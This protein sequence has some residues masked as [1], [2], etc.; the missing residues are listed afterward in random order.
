MVILMKLRRLFILLSNISLASAAVCFFLIINGGS[1]IFLLITILS[2][3]INI[4][5]IP[6]STLKDIFIFLSSFNINLS[7]S[8]IAIITS[9]YSTSTLF[10]FYLKGVEL[11]T[12]KPYFKNKRLISIIFS[13]FLPFIFLILMILFILLDSINLLSMLIIYIILYLLFQY[14]LQ[15][16]ALKTINTKLLYKGI[17]FS[18]LFTIIF[19]FSFIIY[20]DN[21][22]FKEI[23]GIFS[24]LIGF[25]L[26]LYINI[27]GLYLGIY[28][29]WKNIV[30]SNY[31]I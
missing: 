31:F 7:S 11:I 10:K 8:I 20:L 15:G 2:R 17:L 30:D 18:L 29:N 9:I 21:F 16:F 14:I 24:I 22:K 26:Y 5:I 6:D 3:I 23:Y 19:S 28:Y 12:N 4:N 13:I 27:I 25:I 1:T